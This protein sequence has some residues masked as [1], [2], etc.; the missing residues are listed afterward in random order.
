M[1]I[2]SQDG[3]QSKYLKYFQNYHLYSKKIQMMK[4]VSKKRKTGRF[5]IIK[6]ASMNIKMPTACECIT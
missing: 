6:V 2:F 4:D 5:G 1:E 3:L